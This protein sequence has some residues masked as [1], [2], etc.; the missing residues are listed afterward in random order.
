MSWSDSKFPYMRKYRKDILLAEIPDFFLCTT[1]SQQVGGVSRSRV[2]HTV[3][4]QP[5][6]NIASSNSHWAIELCKPVSNLLSLW[7]GCFK[8]WTFP[9]KKC[10]LKW[11]DQKKK[12]KI[13]IKRSK[14]NL[15]RKG[16]K[17]QDKE[18]LC[19]LKYAFQ[20]YKT[21]YSVCVR[22]SKLIENKCAGVWRSSVT[23][24]YHTTKHRDL[25][26]CSWNRW[27]L[28]MFVLDIEPI[29]PIA[30]VKGSTRHT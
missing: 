29:V 25:Q 11:K 10:N 30:Y 2:S 15:K 1:F 3:S 16:K 18:T 7:W 5:V 6:W 26:R 14:T 17:I 28:A 20:Q 9:G 19:K 13:T 23:G 24:W 27:H 21:T 12:N 22:T 8:K 4:R